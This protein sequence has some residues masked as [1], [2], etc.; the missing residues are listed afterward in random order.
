MAWTKHAEGLWSATDTLRGPIRLPLRMTVMAVEGGLALWSPVPIDDTLARRIDAVGEVRFVVAPNLMHHLHARAAKERYPE[1]LMVGPKALTDKVGLELDEAIENTDCFGEAIALHA[2]AGAPKMQ[3]VVALH[4][5]TRSLVV[6]D[7]VFNIHTADGWLTRLVLRYLSR[8]YGELAQSRLWRM[9]T[10]DRAA[11][12]ESL[13]P[14]VAA[15]FDRLVVAHGEVIES[16]ASQ[17]F[18]ASLAWMLG[19][20]TPRLPAATARAGRG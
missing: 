12:R 20:E 15:D 16:G 2:V 11:A 10:R 9:A 14:L 18:L 5:S 19:D 1:A 8:A 7:L 13:L 4:R 6:T 17:P 3:E